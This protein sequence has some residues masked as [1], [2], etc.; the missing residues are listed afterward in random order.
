MWYEEFELKCMK[1]W[2]FINDDVMFIEMLVMCCNG[3]VM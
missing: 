3:F 2:G 1:K